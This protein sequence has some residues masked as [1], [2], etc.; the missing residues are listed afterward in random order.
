M[1]EENKSELALERQPSHTSISLSGTEKSGLSS[2]RTE[3][4]EGYHL[5][6][7]IADRQLK[8]LEGNITTFG[9]FVENGKIVLALLRHFG[10]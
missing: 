3:H 8:D 1:Q 6:G 4:E 7:E 5:P 2:N 10:W 9:K